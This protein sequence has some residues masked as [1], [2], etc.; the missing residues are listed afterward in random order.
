MSAH[1]GRMVSGGR[2]Q[3]PAE[4]RRILGI[5][6]GDPLIMEV[7]D[8]ELRIRSHRASIQRIQA[9]VRAFVPAGVSLA[10]EL[11]A[12]RRREAENE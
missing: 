9:M 2:I 12:D 6:D 1:R 4:V 5:A 7:V 3:V 10:D 8:D 11:I